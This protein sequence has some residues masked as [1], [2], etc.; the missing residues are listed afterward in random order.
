MLFCNGKIVVG[1]YK[2]QKHPFL[3]ELKVSYIRKTIKLKISN[4]TIIESVF[5]APLRKFLQTFL[6]L[7]HL[8]FIYCVFKT[9]K[10]PL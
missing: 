9:K 10:T 2:T 7:H 8:K 3:S 1:M 6:Y 4:Q 5:T